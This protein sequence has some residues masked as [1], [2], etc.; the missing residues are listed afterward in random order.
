MS[1]LPTY[2]QKNA[3]GYYHFRRIFPKAIPGQLGRREF[4]RSLKTKDPRK[5][6]LLAHMLKLRVDP[7]FNLISR[8]K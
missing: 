8:T 3:F 5:A 4:K 2:L 7:L 1:A 6:T